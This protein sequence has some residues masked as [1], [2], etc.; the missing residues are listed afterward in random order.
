MINT[1]TESMPAGPITRVRYFL[2]VNNIGDRM[3]PVIVSETSGREAMWYRKGPEK[4][5]LAV[6]S[7]LRSA[8]PNSFVW[9]S[10]V[11]DP[12][13]DLSGV[14]PAQIVA[15]RGKLSHAALT[16]QR[17]RLPDM[18]L[19]DPGFL[20]PSA[21][22]RSN[23]DRPLRLGIAAHYV[24]AALPAVRA[25][26]RQPG[27]TLIDATDPPDQYFRALASCQAVIGSS[28]HGLIFAE[29][30]GIPN[31]WVQFEHG[32]PRADF[33][34][35]DWFTT[36]DA[37]QATAVTVTGA[38]K[39]EALARH[40]ALHDCRID[41][42]ELAAALTPDVLDACRET[43]PPPRFISLKACRQRPVPVF[44]ISLNQ[45]RALLKSIA[46]VRA[47]ATPCEIVVIDLGSDDSSTLATLSNL[48][49]AG[50]TVYRRRRKTRDKPSPRFLRK[51]IGSFFGSAA[52]GR[53]A[54]GADEKLFRFV[55]KSIAAFFDRWAEPVPYVVADCAVDIG[56]TRSDLL[57]VLANVLNRIS[58]LQCVGP[59]L[60]EDGVSARPTPDI[61]AKALDPGE[62]SGI[63]RLPTAQGEIAY[64]R[65]YAELPFAMHRPS[66]SFNPRRR[67]AVVFNW[68]QTNRRAAP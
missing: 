15:L 30:L 23:G 21:L 27:V 67:G 1:K 51:A 50:T 66:L 43:E 40:C 17:G 4:H 46:S 6:G 9:G 12:E 62:A 16:R 10:G 19:G 61:S 59:A 36:T 32:L 34:Y 48:Q 29:A 25:L 2:K 38:E 7:V 31:L 45:P 63:Q 52:V 11:M 22:R 56:S 49:R 54:D 8:G 18:P 24:D 41:R 60:P 5:L 64:R 26:C 3:S 35:R 57:D 68:E 42:S 13:L 20:V 47:L 65:T 44:V 39:P 37:P 33:K 55:A 53:Q 58:D 28:L 14:M